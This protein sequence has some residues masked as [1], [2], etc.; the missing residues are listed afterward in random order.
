MMNAEDGFMGPVP[1]RI[2]AHDSEQIPPFSVNTINTWLTV[3]GMFRHGIESA[4]VAVALGHIDGMNRDYGFPVTPEAWDQNDKPWGSMY[5]GWDESILLLL[6][7]RIAGIDFNLVRDKLDI[8]SHLPDQWQFVEVI[9]PILKN[10]KPYWVEVKTHRHR[11]GD[12]WQK[13]TTIK[14]NVFKT[15]HIVPWQENH[16]LLSETDSMT[17]E[18]KSDLSFRII[19]GDRKPDVKHH[20]WR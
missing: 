9:V 7:E 1:F 3:E 16:I 6:I 20:L 2:R 11:V 4:A 14:D 19:L 17:V 8:A 13:T 10:G 18:N 12:R 15:V 5:Y